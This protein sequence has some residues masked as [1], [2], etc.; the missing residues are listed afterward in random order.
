MACSFDSQELE[1]WDEFECLFLFLKTGWGGNLRI[2][3]FLFRVCW[4]VCTQKLPKLMLFLLSTP[5]LILSSLVFFNVL[6][7]VLLKSVVMFAIHKGF[8]QP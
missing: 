6:F 8:K 3:F 7:I 1:Y 5:F 2:Y 4:I